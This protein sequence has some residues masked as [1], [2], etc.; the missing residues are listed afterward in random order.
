MIVAGTMP[1]FD[2]SISTVGARTSSGTA[3]ESAKKF[4]EKSAETQ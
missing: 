3:K 2:F 1:A 4:A